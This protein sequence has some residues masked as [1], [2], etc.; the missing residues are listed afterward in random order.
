MTV[1]GRMLGK[2]LN[3]DS[4]WSVSTDDSRA[5]ENSYEATN[6]SGKKH[7]IKRHMVG[8]R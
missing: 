4:F 1:N 8:Y 3:K 2:K 7:T 5:E 6:A